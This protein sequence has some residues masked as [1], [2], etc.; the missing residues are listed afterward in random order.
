MA[1]SD[2][3]QSIASPY[4]VASVQSTENNPGRPNVNLKLSYQ[5]PYFE[6]LVRPVRKLFKA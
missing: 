3:Y 4:A 2:R 1:P 6:T 5:V